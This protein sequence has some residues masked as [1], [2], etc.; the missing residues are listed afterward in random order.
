MDSR[1]QLDH[2]VKLDLPVWKEKGNILSWHRKMVIVTRHISSIHLHKKYGW[3]KRLLTMVVQ[4][5]QVKLPFMHVTMKPS[6]LVTNRYTLDR[7]E[8]LF[9][10]TLLAQRVQ[11]T[12]FTFDS[13][14]C[15]LKYTLHIFVVD[16][17]STEMRT[18]FNSKPTYIMTAESTTLSAYSDS[19]YT[20]TLCTHLPSL[21]CDSC[22]LDKNE[23]IQSLFTPALPTTKLVHSPTR[24]S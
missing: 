8:G 6:Q 12:L 21:L 18:C 1:E 16:K 3:P 5:L 10:L 9:T 15:M 20:S 17:L 19:L 4:Y 14:S 11:L 23:D 24:E 22:A 7:S 13:Q 2:R